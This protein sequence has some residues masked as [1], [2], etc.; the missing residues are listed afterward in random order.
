[1]VRS[2]RT[3]LFHNLF[4]QF[5]YITHLTY[6]RKLTRAKTRRIKEVIDQAHKAPGLADNDPCSAL[7]RLSSLCRASHHLCIID[8]RRE[9]T[10]QLMSNHSDKLFLDRKSTRLNSSHLVIS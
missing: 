3:Q 7:D 1:M 6:Q 4:G 8:D 2:D 9:R 10:S 5:R